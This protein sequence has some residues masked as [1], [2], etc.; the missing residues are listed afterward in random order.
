MTVGVTVG[1]TV[2]GAQAQRTAGRATGRLAAY[3]D[4]TVT[5]STIA[6]LPAARDVAR[7]DADVCYRIKRKSSGCAVKTAF[8]HNGLFVG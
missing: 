5:C 1:V 2:I 6:E 3:P 8:D 4:R 7:F